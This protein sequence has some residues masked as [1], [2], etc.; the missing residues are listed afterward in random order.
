M[1][2]IAYNQ[3]MLNT[4][5]PVPNSTKRI[6][7]FGGGTVM[8]VRNHMALCA[9]AY[10]ATAKKMVSLLGGHEYEIDLL[11][12]KMADSS[13]QME[14]NNDVGEVLMNVLGDPR[15]AGIVF[16]VA[17]CDFSGH[18]GSVPS[19][20][21]AERLQ[22][23]QVTEDGLALTLHP[24]KKLLALVREMRPDIVSVGFKTTA[25]EPVQ[26]Q[27]DKSNRMAY[28]AGVAWMLANDTVT[29]NN[30]VLQNADGTEGQ[31]LKDALYNG[32]DR[33]V[34]LKILAQKFIN[35]IRKK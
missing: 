23:R 26:A 32:Q 1:R 35:D 6:V 9:P 2:R 5:A 17:L 13:S 34:A 29:R 8:Y 18:I 21:H 4:T 11:L 22:T 33:D 12:T 3:G 27:I 28:E 15:I 30:I 31:T 24:T 25:N 10:G 7:V 19:G 20:K 14:T 16:N